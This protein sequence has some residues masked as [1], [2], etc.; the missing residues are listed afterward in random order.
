MKMLDQVMA[1]HSRANSVFKKSKDAE[2]LSFNTKH[3]I[4]NTSSITYFDAVVPEQQ[5]K[6]RVYLRTLNSL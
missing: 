6:A 1:D 4:E 3:E 5:L 2:L